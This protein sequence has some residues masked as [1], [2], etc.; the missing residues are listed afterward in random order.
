MVLHVTVDFVSR[1]LCFCP[2]KHAKL[3]TGPVRGSDRVA[4]LRDLVYRYFENGR[5]ELWDEET[6]TLLGQSRGYHPTH[7]S[8]TPEGLIDAER[9]AHHFDLASFIRMQIAAAS[10]PQ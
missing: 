1:K 5:L 3:V 8:L 4:P 10:D 7:L 9:D 2:E 6:E